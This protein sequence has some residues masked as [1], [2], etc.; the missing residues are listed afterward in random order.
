MTR[1]VRRRTVSGIGALVVVLVGYLLFFVN[2]GDGTADPAVAST[3]GRTDGLTGVSATD[4]ATFRASSAGADVTIG[5][6]VVG[7]LT[8]SYLV[9]APAAAPGRLPVLVVLHGSDAS[10]V[11]EALRDE[12]VTLAQQDQAIIVYPSSYTDDLTWNVDFASCCQAAGSQ[13]IADAAFIQ[14]LVPSL[15][16]AYAPTAIDLVGFSNGGKLAFDLTCKDSSLFDAV[17]VVS[18]LPLQACT[19]PPVSMLIAIG[20]A[21][22]REPLEDA[23]SPLSATVQLED[24]VAAW[25]TRDGCDVTASSAQIG[26]VTQTTSTSCASATKVSEVSYEGI[27]HIWPRSNDVGPTA[28]AATVIWAFFAGLEQGHDLS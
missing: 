17:A 28:S 9:I 12:L 4:L 19:G 24:A 10:A 6:I 23:V 22:T 14:L 13:N 27:G 3:T 21:D 15:R 2:S 8:R 25:R 5:S 18:A 7:R 11:T 1:A 16:A 20:T 26:V